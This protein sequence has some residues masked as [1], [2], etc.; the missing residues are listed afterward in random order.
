MTA[1]QRVES[2]AGPVAVDG[3]TITLVARTTALHVGRDRFGAVHA[4][5]RPLHVEVLDEHGER[6]VMRIR[7]TERMLVGAIALAGIVGA[8]V[9]R[10]IRGAGGPGGPGG[11]G[12]PGGE[13]GSRRRRAR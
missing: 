3:R 4:R 2:T 12:G 10:G 7:D 1:L 11:L 9:L 13:S 8:W 6:H 5:A